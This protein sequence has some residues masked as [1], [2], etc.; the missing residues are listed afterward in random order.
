VVIVAIG[1]QQWRFVNDAGLFRYAANEQRF[2]RAVDFANSLPA[3]TIL[4]S[5]AYSGTLRFYSG[6]DVLRWE[7]IPAKQLDEVLVY[8]RDHGHP[9]Y[10]V[11]DPFEEDDF[12]SYFAGADAMRQFDNSR[13]ADVAYGFVAADLTPR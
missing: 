5:N 10:F 12:K 11:G 7:S 4:V 13:I 8:L 1:I 6:R 9:A 2:A 3:N